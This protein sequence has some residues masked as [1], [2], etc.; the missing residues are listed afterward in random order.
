VTLSCALCLLLFP[1][2]STTLDLSERGPLNNSAQ[3][4]P[5]PSISGISQD[6]YFLAATVFE[7]KASKCLLLCLHIQRS[8][9]IIKAIKNIA[10]PIPISISRKRPSLM[11]FILLIFFGDGE[12]E[13]IIIMDEDLVA[14]SR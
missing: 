6:Y 7:E 4:T 1:A 12:G 11:M 10:I 14:A 2:I 8:H 9:M 3:S 5:L 13:L